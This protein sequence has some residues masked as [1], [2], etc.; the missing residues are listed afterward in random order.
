MPELLDL[1]FAG[2]ARNLVDDFNR[3][4]LL[5]AHLPPVREAPVGALRVEIVEIGRRFPRE[6]ANS[7]LPAPT[8]R[9]FGGGLV[10]P[11]DADRAMRRRA[12][13]PI[14]RLR[15]ADIG[16]CAGI[17]QDVAIAGA[18]HQTQL[19]GMAVTRAPG[20][21]RT[22]VDQNMRSEERRV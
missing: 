21:E 20:P 22:G 15:I 2:R 17:D 12:A 10:E 18:N 1:V 19:A 8:E 6:D 5:E 11:T 14:A 3:A 4:R 16:V 13:E 9:S 7:R